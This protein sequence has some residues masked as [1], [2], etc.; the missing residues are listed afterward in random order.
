MELLP[1]LH[2]SRTPSAVSGFKEPGSA[3]DS[4]SD[5]QRKAPREDPG[6]PACVISMCGYQ[7]NLRMA[8]IWV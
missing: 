2:E 3:A 6:S 5:G 1:V 7:V 8:T 4:G